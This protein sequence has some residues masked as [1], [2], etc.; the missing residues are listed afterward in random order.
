VGT[1]TDAEVLE[2]ARLDGTVSRAYDDAAE[3]VR[4]ANLVIFCVYARHIPALMRRCADDFSP[5]VLISDICG[6]KS[7]LYDMLAPLIPEG[8]SYVGIHPMAGKERDGFDNADPAIYKG[9]GMIICPLPRTKPGSVGLIRD[10][11]DHIGVTRIVVSPVDKHDEI[12]AYTSDLMHIS[13]AA[14]CMDFHPDMNLAFTAGAFHD[15]TRVA[16]INAAAW[17]ELLMANAANT[18][19]ALDKY[20]RRLNEVRGALTGGDEEELT[21]LL[22]LGGRNKREMLKK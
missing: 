20:I 16:D 7:R 13:A 4:G 9:A 12:I 19:A 2:K 21:R 1:D 18:A 3:A 17:T 6:V 8:A 5:G 15:C 11:A 10:L 22:D 14:L